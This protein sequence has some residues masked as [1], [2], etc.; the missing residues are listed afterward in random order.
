MQPSSPDTR[1]PTVQLPAKLALACLL[2]SFVA[3]DS[4][5]S[6]TSAPATKSASATPPSP[7]PINPA[8]AIPKPPK[9]DVLR[10]RPGLVDNTG[11]HG[12]RDARVY[13]DGRL[14]VLTYD[15]GCA[16]RPVLLS[17]RN[18]SHLDITYGAVARQPAA[19][20]SFLGPFTAVVKLPLTVNLQRP[21]AVTVH[22]DGAAAYTLTARTA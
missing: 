8:P 3:C 12:I 7:H 11:W 17:V 4:A 9:P 1:L 10:F 19:C 21:L 6:P 16:R 18:A 13:P 5:R 2:G 22:F 14:A 15:G 20:L